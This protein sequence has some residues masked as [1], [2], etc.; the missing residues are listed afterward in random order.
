MLK[1]I[2]IFG[3]YL[4]PILGYMAAATLLWLPLC[5]LLQ[6]LR[7]Y[8]LVWHPALFNAALYLLLLAGMALATS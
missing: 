6:W 1:E 4:P 8:R 7:F 2:S 3:V 5:R